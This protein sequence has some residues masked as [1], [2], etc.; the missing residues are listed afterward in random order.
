MPVAQKFVIYI[1]LE[2]S[3]GKLE[4]FRVS[5]P[6]SGETFTEGLKKAAKI[7]DFEHQKRVL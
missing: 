3:D 2:M 1:N 5:V 7:H 6:G 4:T